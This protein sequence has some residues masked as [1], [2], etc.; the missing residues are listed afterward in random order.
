MKHLPRT[1]LSLVL[2]LLASISLVNTAHAQDQIR[3][4]R[5]LLQEFC[6]PCHAI[7]RTGVSHRAPPF[8]QLG[9]N[10]DLDQFPR[11]LERGISSTH[12]GM[13]EFK[14]SEDDAHA[15]AAYLRSIQR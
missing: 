6:T 5:A 15:A 14:F 10:F 7:G 11:L 3:R 8:S 2:G 13:P 12:P 4:G 9:R 1:F